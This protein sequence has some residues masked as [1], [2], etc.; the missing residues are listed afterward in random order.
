[1]NRPALMLPLVVLLLAGTGCVKKSAH[2]DKA[3]AGA[4]GRQPE[5]GPK[6]GRQA[7]AGDSLRIFQ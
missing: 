6:G 4:E 5:P 2:A 3:E 1:M 7:G